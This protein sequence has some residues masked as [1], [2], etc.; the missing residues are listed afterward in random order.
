[1]ARWKTSRTERP[2]PACPRRWGA[3]CSPPTPLASVTRLGSPVD[4]PGG[5]RRGRS[6]PLACPPGQR[7]FSGLWRGGRLGEAAEHRP[8]RDPQLPRDCCLGHAVR[9]RLPHDLEIEVEARTPRGSYDRAVTF[10][11]AARTPT[12]CP[13]QATAALSFWRVD[14]HAPMIPRPRSE[15]GMGDRSA[16]SPPPTSVSEWRCESDCRTTRCGRSAA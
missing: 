6:H 3:A 13:M 16:T 2:S 11:P 12:A 15:R 14:Q 5:D 9:Q 1:M 8:T 4:L 7:R 10:C